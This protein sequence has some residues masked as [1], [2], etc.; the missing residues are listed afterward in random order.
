M[1]DIELR[2]YDEISASILEFLELYTK[3]TPEEI[4]KLKDSTKTRGK[5]DL[6]QR[7]KIL[8]KETTKDIMFAIWGNVQGKSVMHKRIEFGPYEAALPT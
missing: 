6:T 1:R 2:K 3:L 5:G 8:L 7:E 4:A